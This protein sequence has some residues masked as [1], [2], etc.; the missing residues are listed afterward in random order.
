MLAYNANTW[1]KQESSQRMLRTLDG[2]ARTYLS[3]R[4]RRIDNIDIAG[5]TLP[6]LGGLPDIRFESCQITESRMYIKAVNPRLQANPDS[7]TACPISQAA[8]AT[9]NWTKSIVPGPATTPGSFFRSIRSVYQQCGAEPCNRAGE[10]IIS[11]KRRT[12][13]VAP[14]SA[15]LLSDYHKL[16]R[17][18][19]CRSVST[20]ATTPRGRFRSSGK[21]Q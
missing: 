13:G 4:Y 7:Q 18:G 19:R 20:C 10:P 6:I 12:D 2:S 14:A 8:S 5:V 9:K 21:V 3:N 17:Q 11:I 16:Q 15:R 1:F